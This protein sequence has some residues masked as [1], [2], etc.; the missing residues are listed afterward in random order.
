MS[1]TSIAADWVLLWLSTRQLGRS[2]VT[3]SL[4]TSVI[5]R[6][7]CFRLQGSL[8]CLRYSAGQKTRPHLSREPPLPSDRRRHPFHG[9]R[10]TLTPERLK[11]LCPPKEQKH[12]LILSAHFVS[13]PGQRRNRTSEIGGLGTSPVMRLPGMFLHFRF[14]LGF[15]GRQSGSTLVS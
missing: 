15:A 14:A 2:A 10:K 3:S 4:P 12:P 9:L 6:K 7:R 5:T 11:K 1:L 13:V 8:R